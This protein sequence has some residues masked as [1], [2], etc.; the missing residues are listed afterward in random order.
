[1]GISNAQELS[2]TNAEI[3]TFFYKWEDANNNNLAEPDEYEFVESNRGF[4]SY[5]FSNMEDDNGLI[6]LP[7]HFEGDG[8]PLEDSTYYLVAVQY[9]SSNDLLC[10]FMASE[11]FNYQATAFLSDSLQKNRYSSIL[12]LNNTGT[13]D[14]IGFG[15][16]VVPVV[17][18]H[19]GT[20]AD[21]TIPGVMVST[22]GVN[23]EKKT[24]VDVS[25]NPNFG[26]FDLN[27]Q[28]ENLSRYVGIKL[29][30]MSGSILFSDNYENIQ[31]KQLNLSFPT[32]PP[33][34]YCL[35]VQTD[36]QVLSKKI[37]VVRTV[38]KILNNIRKICGY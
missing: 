14:F 19:I 9:I 13:F 16:D 24:K 34:T 33:G 15:L 30:N 4:N 28:L 10:E 6:T 32:I 21:L 8:I 20:V 11:Q 12:D 25:P 27:I 22:E 1:M 23:Y 2:E 18:L 38:T 37:I 31:Q 36:V 29:L 7:V 17:R 35:Q 5:P 3:S 26:Q